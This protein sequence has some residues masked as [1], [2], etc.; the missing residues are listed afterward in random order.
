MPPFT[1]SISTPRTSPT[2]AEPKSLGSIGF[3]DSAGLLG[4]LQSIL[5]G[6]QKDGK[7][8]QKGIQKCGNWNS[9]TRGSI[10]YRLYKDKRV[11]V[12]NLETCNSPDCP[13]CSLKVNTKKTKAL[14]KA[15]QQVRYEE[16][17]IAFI[18]T[19]TRPMKD[20]S[21]GIKLIQDFNS[22]AQK[23]VNNYTRKYDIQD[24]GLSYATIEPTFS[25]KR[26]YKDEEGR[27]VKG[28]YYVHTHSHMIV[29][30]S[31]I[32]IEQR[33]MKTL[34]DRLKALW[35]KVVKEH[36]AYSQVQSGVGFMYEYVD[37]T[38]KISTYMTKLM[39]T[40]SISLELTQSQVKKGGGFHL[41]QLLQ[42]INLEPD[43]LYSKVHRQNIRD[44]FKYIYRQNRQKSYG[45]ER[46]VAKFKE[47]Q[48]EI[49]ESYVKKSTTGLKAYTEGVIDHMCVSQPLE[50]EIAR[51][52][53]S[54]KEKGWTF[55]F[56]EDS[57]TPSP[58]TQQI[59][60]SETIH[61]IELVP[62]RVYNLFRKLGYEDTL[63]E[64]FIGYHF[65]DTYKECYNEFKTLSFRSSVGDIYR[66]IRT[67]NVANILKGSFNIKQYNKGNT[68]E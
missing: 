48:R 11:S 34:I 50:G 35:I 40:T 12:S 1:S 13:V 41:F 23:V 62:P 45:L 32:V 44:W 3:I 61:V 20:V 15:L 37:N 8:I 68:H 19:T 55:Y 54:L 42:K 7:P 24:K 31:K 22:K 26:C 17:E 4:T 39:N 9:F 65:D 25:R 59:I 60:D 33:G 6:L 57:W 14:T 52:V 49:I 36:R 66:F 21:R 67:C 63:K 30:L 27:R 2:Q 28:F 29:G 51:P 47:R 64:L 56:E 10:E 58:I 53:K 38:D 43:T 46:Y 5:K 16:G 18:T